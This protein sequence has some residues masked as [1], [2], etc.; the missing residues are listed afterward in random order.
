M[1]TMHKHP[2]WVILA[3]CLLATLSACSKNVPDSAKNMPESAAPEDK[4]V[5]ASMAGDLQ[6]VKALIESDA[7]LIDAI[8][9]NNRTPL[10]FAAAYGQNEVVKFLLEKGASIA[11]NDDNDES[12]IDAA[13]QNAHTDT[14]KIIVEY[15]K[16]QPAAGG[17]AS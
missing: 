8:D 14:A 7:T 12:P 5:A 15:S 9:N 6:K 4:I 17:A 10:H 16:N 13:V 11:A 3:I 2:L 1:S